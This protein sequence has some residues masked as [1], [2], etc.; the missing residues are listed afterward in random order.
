MRRP[1]YAHGRQPVQPLD[2]YGEKA[3]KQKES[4]VE[5]SKVNSDSGREK[6]NFESDLSTVTTRDETQA[7]DAIAGLLTD[8]RTLYCVISHCIRTRWKEGSTYIVLLAGL[9][10]IMAYLTA[11]PGEVSDC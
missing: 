10:F 1:P 6:Q 7:D 3:R 11:S 4:R 5:Q 8:G 9:Q 2:H